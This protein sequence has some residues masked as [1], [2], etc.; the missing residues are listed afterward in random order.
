M[1]KDDGSYTHIHTV[2]YYSTIKNN[3]I[4]PF[5]ATWMDLYIIILSEMMQGK[6]NI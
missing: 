3:K 2:E 5:T 1:D 6:A 4:M